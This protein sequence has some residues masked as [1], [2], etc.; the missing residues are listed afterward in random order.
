MYES[1]TLPLEETRARVGEFG[2]LGEGKA[3]RLDFG[4][5]VGSS[6]WGRRGAVSRSGGL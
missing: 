1:K 5:H 3:W 2:W 4:S 6:G